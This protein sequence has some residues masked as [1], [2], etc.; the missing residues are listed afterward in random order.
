MKVG[1]KRF[2]LELECVRTYVR[3]IAMPKVAKTIKIS[4]HHEQWLDAHNINFSAWIRKKIDAEIERENIRTADGPCKAV[5]LAAGKDKDLFPLTE[6][7]PKAMLD[8]KGRSILEWQVE[9]LKRVGITEIAV[10]RGYKKQMI[11]LPGLRYFDN[12][13]Y[14]TTGTLMSLLAARDFLDNTTIV[15]YGDI[16][17][18][19]GTIRRL[20]ADGDT[21]T[22]V[23]DKGWKKRYLSSLEGHPLPPELATLHESEQAIEISSLTVGMQ[24]NNGAS[25]FIGLAKLASSACEVLKN[26]FAGASLNGQSGINKAGLNLQEA[27]F[28][29]FIQ[30]LLKRGEKVTALEIWRNWIEVDTFE[31]YRNAWIHINDLMDY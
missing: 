12:D 20:L 3:I 22:L 10:V 24:E 17:F 1:L 13:D 16:L 4:A 31:D 18:D 8:I 7:R 30:A 28:I 6:D 9:L 15:L 14:E 21:T 11:N 26:L 2:K 29:E 23:V 27:S 5:I 25:E 19:T